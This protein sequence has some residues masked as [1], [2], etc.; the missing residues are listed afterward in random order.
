VRDGNW[1]GLVPAGGYGSLA[2][3]TTNVQ[4]DYVR[5]YA[6]VPEPAG[7]ALAALTGLAMRRRPRCDT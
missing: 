4:V 5:A 6:A 2:T 3:S 7:L 1:A